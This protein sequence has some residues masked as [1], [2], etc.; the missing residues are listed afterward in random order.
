MQAEFFGRIFSPGS[1]NDM[2]PDPLHL[3]GSRAKRRLQGPFGQPAD[4]IYDLGR[5]HDYCRYYLPDGLPSWF[6]YAWRLEGGG[7]QAMLLWEKA[8]CNGEV[9]IVDVM[10][11][12]KQYGRLLQSGRKDGYRCGFERGMK[13]VVSLR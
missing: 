10:D 11:Q 2:H 13:V 7:L 1:G 5:C 8:T 12:M 4:H 6:C 3:P 9:G